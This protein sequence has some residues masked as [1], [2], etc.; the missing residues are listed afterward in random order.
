[1]RKII[2]GALACALAAGCQTAATTTEAEPE[3]AAPPAGSPAAAATAFYTAVMSLPVG[4]VPDAAGQERL[5]PL[6]TSDLAAKLAAAR[7]AEEAHT[8]ATGNEEP[9]MLQGDI[10]GSLFE[11]RTAFIVAGCEESGNGVHCEV[12]QSFSDQSGDSDWTDTV[13]LVQEDGAWKVA[14]VIYG[15]D[16]DFAN[17]GRLTETL[18]AVAAAD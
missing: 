2:G 5:Q 6:V 1:M 17:R 18:D 7:A 16:W 12:P 3:V 11:G 10:F 15:G 9:P 4:G 14:D 13:V 8:A